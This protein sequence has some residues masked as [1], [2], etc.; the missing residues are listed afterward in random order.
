M[1]WKDGDGM[2]KNQQ[3]NT[4]NLRAYRRSNNL[5]VGARTDLHG[6]FVFIWRLCISFYNLNKITR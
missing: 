5:G 2:V 3:G 6:N 4:T 1:G